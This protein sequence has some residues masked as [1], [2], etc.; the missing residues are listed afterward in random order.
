MLRTIPVSERNAAVVPPRVVTLAAA[1][2]TE[3]FPDETRTREEIITRYIQNMTGDDLYVAY[4]TDQCDNLANYHVVITDKQL[5]EL[6]PVRVKVTVF[7]VGGGKLSTT[8]IVR[9]DLTH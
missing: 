8:K 7:S 2:A 6:L 5:L 1:T 9:N 3:A 4:G